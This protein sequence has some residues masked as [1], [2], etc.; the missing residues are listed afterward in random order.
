M[1]A[2][3]LNGAGGASSHL[4]R[5]FDASSLTTRFIIYEIGFEPCGVSTVWTVVDA[6]RIV[7]MRIEAHVEK[8]RRFDRL[9]SR[10]DPEADFELWYWMTLN[11][12]TA[13]INAALHAAGTTREEDSFTTQIANIYWVPGPQG[14]RHLA[15]RFGVDI[16]HVGM[17][18]INQP[19]PPAIAAAF[20]EMHICIIS[21][22]LYS[23]KTDR[24]P[25]KSSAPAPMLTRDVW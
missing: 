25:T 8:F 22:S 11:A 2:P 9:R 21:R 4:N 16:I 7:A 18:K 13:I 5:H 1:R 19:L 3:S 24:S 20:D 23:A 10:F 12:G 6:R 17:P 14:T 15:D